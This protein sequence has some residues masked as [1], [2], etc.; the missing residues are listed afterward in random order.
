MYADLKKVGLTWESSLTVKCGD[1]EQYKPSG[2]SAALCPWPFSLTGDDWKDEMCTKSRTGC[3]G[4][5]EPDL[6][7]MP[8]YMLGKCGGDGMDPQTASSG[9]GDIG[10]VLDDYLELRGSTNKAPLG[11]FLH[12][13]WLVGNDA[14][15]GNGCKNGEALAAWLK[16]VQEAGTVHLVTASDLLNWMNKPVKNSELIK[17]RTEQCKEY[18][19]ICW[20]PQNGATVDCG[21]PTGSRGEFDAETC[22]CNC[23]VVSGVRYCPDSDGRC[24]VV[25][26]PDPGSC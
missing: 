12:G 24:T 21:D 11:I 1:P 13:A 3:D 16:K 17:Q 2:G 23:K 22:T 20:P 18:K 9:C 19:K 4:V 10:K 26:Y 7:E 5:D 8:M 25:K 15:E 14:C 6:A